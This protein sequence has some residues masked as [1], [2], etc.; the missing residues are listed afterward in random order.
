MKVRKKIAIHQPQYL[1]WPGYFDKMDRADM[2]VLLDDVQ[3]KKNE[4]QNRNRIRTA[5][6]WQWL[7]V[8][9]TYSF[10]DRIRQVSVNTAEKWREKHGKSLYYNY[11]KAEYFRKY[12]PIFEEAFSREWEKL[13]ELNVFFIRELAAVIGIDTQV[14]FSS[15]IETRASATGRLVEI[16]SAFGAD[17]YLSGQ[18]GADYLD[19]ELFAE[20]GIE[21]EYQSYSPAEYDQV[22]KP[23]IPG[24]SVA[25]MLFCTGPGCL[26]TIRRG[27]MK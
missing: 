8:P 20:A 27:R 16:C 10:G 9:V 18:G 19:E 14:V 13:A 6:G 4:W 21:L 24:L 26:K 15:G 3:Y 11:S 5:S 17:V 1:P 25:D 12:Y 23:F 2:F 7:T 22:Y